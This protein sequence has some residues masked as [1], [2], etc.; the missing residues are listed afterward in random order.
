MMPEIEQQL[1]T[2]DYDNNIATIT[3]NNPPANVLSQAVIEQ[4][5]LT[6]Q[7]LEQIDLAAIIVT[8]QGNHSFCAGADIQELTMNDL[9][10]NKN[11]FSRI[12]DTFNL[13]ASYKHPVIAAINGYAYG[14]GLELALCTDIRVM[15]ESARLSAVCVNL[16]LVFGTQRLIRLV[17]PG[18]AKDLI[19]CARS[20]E[21]A[22]ALSFGLAE[23]VVAPGTTWEKAREIAGLIGKKGQRAV[24]GVKQ[25]LN[26]GVNLP[27]D[28]ALELELKSLYRMLG[29]SE[30]ASR[31]R[32]FL[33]K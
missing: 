3:I 8:G 28:Q 5:S 25:V 12:Y 29:T 13:I 24:Q 27:L 22:Q 26:L 16:N 30:F 17:G 2:T 23:H 21:A 20:V 9:S 32:R 6:F 19:F 7:K 31:A 14:A 1:V 10:Q 11:Y 18:R 4:L 33:T 15:D